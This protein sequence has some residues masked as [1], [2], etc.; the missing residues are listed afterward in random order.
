MLVLDR[1]VF[2]YGFLD[3]SSVSVVFS[4]AVLSLYQRGLFQRNRG[5]FRNDFLGVSSAWFFPQRFYR[6]ISVVYF[7]GSFHGRNNGIK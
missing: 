2:R 5:V 7:N 6:C 1:G 3:V 4:T